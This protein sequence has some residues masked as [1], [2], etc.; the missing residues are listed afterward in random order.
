MQYVYWVIENLLAG[1]PGPV[2]APWQPAEFYAA[3]IRVIISLAEEEP[4]DDLSS[5]GFEHLQ[6]KFPP[7]L[8]HSIGMRKAFIHEALPVW[9]FMHARLEAGKPVMVHCH[10]GA[11]RTGLILAGYMVLYRNI[12]PEAAIAQLRALNSAALSAP[13]YA[14]AVALLQPGRLPDPR[15]L[16]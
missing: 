5:Y 1:R 4:V 2:M 10:A 12:Q 6:A 14:E 13:G 16:L 9:E 11:D 15:T 8:L 7:L 3:G